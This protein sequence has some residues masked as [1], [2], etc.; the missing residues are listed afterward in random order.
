M[1]QYRPLRILPL[2]EGK[3]TEPAVLPIL[4]PRI[5]TTLWK[6]LPLLKVVK[7]LTLRSNDLR[8]SDILV[9]KVAGAIRLHEDQRPFA[10][11][12]LFDTDV[13]FDKNTHYDPIA[14]ELSLQR[15]LDTELGH[16]CVP[17]RVVAAVKEF[18]SLFVAAASSLAGTCGLR[19]D[20]EDHPDPEIPR[21]PKGWLE[22][23]GQNGKR[24]KFGIPELQHFASRVDLN[25]AAQRAMWV[26]RL[27]RAVVDLA[28]KLNNN[29]DDN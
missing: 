21:A 7:P 22:S 27:C 8:S 1:T 10:V 25:R 2:V 14:Q 12:I 28:E 29:V 24:V 9:K 5:G 3:L 16:T 19:D 18:E 13:E 15:V 6:L 17:V 4:I 23:N 20:L 26:E 11:L